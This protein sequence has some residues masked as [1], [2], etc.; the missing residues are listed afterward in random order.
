MEE[1]WNECWTY[2]K[3]DY[4]HFRDYATVCLPSL[5]IFFDW[6][7]NERWGKCGRRR[8]GTKFASSLRT[9]WKVSGLVYERATAEKLDAKTSR[10]MHKVLRKLAKKHSLKKIGRD[11][12]CMYVEDLAKVLQTNLMTTEK[13]YPHGR[14]R[15]QAQLYL[16]LGGFTAN[17][18]SALLS[19][20][21]RHI[22]VTLLQD[23]EGGPHRVMLEFTFEFTKQFLG[24]KDQNTFPLHEIMYDETLSF[25]PHVFLLGLLFCDRAFAAYNLVSAEELSR[26]TIP[27][28]RDEL[29][30]HLNQSLDNIPV[31]RKAVRT[32]HGWDISPDEPLSYSTLLPWIRTLG[33][34]TGFAQVTRPYSLRYAGG[35]A[36]NENGNV[37]DAMQNLIMG[38][39]SI[40]TFLRHYLSR[41]I[42]VDTQAVVRGI[43]PQT[44]LMRAACTMSR[45]ID[46][47]RPRRLTP[48]QSASVNNDPS[49]RSLLKQREQLKRTIPNA[50]KHP[51]YKALASKINQERQRRRDALLQAVKERWEFEQPVRDVEWQLAGGEIKDDLELVHLAMLTAQEELADS[52]LSQPGTTIAGELCRRNRA[53]RAVM[54]YCRLEEGGMNPTRIKQGKEKPSPPAKNRSEYKSEALEAAK[55]SVY[56]ETRP[57]IC[58]LSKHFKRKHLQHIKEGESLGCELCQV[59][60]ESKMH[61]QRHAHDIHGTVSFSAT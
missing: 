3:K 58:D 31:F 50:T 7:L 39:A 56:K 55:V 23:P 18:P 10:S 42:T 17:R 25:S 27:P 33:E 20:C 2:L 9:Y 1:Q 21:Y 57:R 30:L 32:L 46:H 61:L 52:V 5:Y 48:E 43:Q 40:T 29:R 36:F 59:V 4:F 53:I 19:L 11:K 54:L 44:A 13:R 28:G 37:S 47:R 41:R 22:Q 38:H 26:L 60:L 8:R 12:A 15:I 24:I 35:K 14:Y 16:Q 6:L 51:K 45:S 49:V 34:I